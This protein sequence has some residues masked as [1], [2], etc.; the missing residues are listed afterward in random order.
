[1]NLSKALSR[2]IKWFLPIS[3]LL[4]N[5]A[6]QVSETDN[7]L[8]EVEVEPQHSVFNIELA[9]PPARLI[10]EKPTLLLTDEMAT[11][12]VWDRIRAGLALQNEYEH[13]AVE[14]ELQWYINNQ[15]YF[16]RIASRAAPFLFWI[17]EQVENR[18]LPLELALVPIVESA[19]NPQA[20]SS[21]HAVGLWQFIRATAASFGLQNDWWYDGRRDPIA[22][23]HA[24]LDYFENLHGRFNDDWLLAM[25]AYNTGEG[26]VSR[27]IRRNARAGKSREFWELR[28]ANETKGHVPR[29]LAIAKLIENADEYGVILP[30]IPNEPYLEIVE[31]DFQL[32]LE[33]AATTASVDPALLRA[34]NPGYLRWATHPDGPHSLVV[35][36]RLSL[37]F[38]DA[39]ATIPDDQR[40]TW[41]RYEIQPGDSLSKIARKYGTQVDILQQVNELR[42]A[43][44]IAGRSLLIPRSGTAG[45][46]QLPA[47]ALGSQTREQ[48]TPTNYRVRQGDNLWS[49]ARRYDIRS[50]D[51]ATWNGIALDALLHPGQILA[52]K[53]ID[54]VA[55]TD[56][57]T[58]HGVVNYRIK[59]GDS[60]DKIASQFGVSVNELA[61]WNKINPLALIHPGQELRIFPKDSTLN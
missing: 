61:N 9:K 41:D 6:C 28:L 53:A 15:S 8:P 47:V 11:I 42:N 14:R 29:I 36:R 37:A 25:A 57:T 43:R 2:H 54:D 1:M 39:V 31:L 23:T 32:D 38:I 59:S 52:L 46:P 45:I 4:V 20:Y 27:A 19:Y 48:I 18:E 3:L 10:S 35:P 13:E 24:A 50:A 7:D 5:A 22:S 33:R 17:V 26:N 49:I 34:L 40:V 56:S 55:S 58:N 21:E 16:D 60:L 51:I 44:I 12:D 30:T